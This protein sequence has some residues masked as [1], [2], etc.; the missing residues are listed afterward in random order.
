VVPSWAVI[1]ILAREF[2]VTALRTVA[3]SVGRVIAA[4]NW[5]KA[6]MVVQVVAISFLLTPL[7]NILLG[8]VSVGDAMMWIMTLITVWSGIDY[9]Y[10]NRDVFLTAK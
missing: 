6:K 3:M 2:I 5:G 4:N 10:V 7:R 9:C 8:F 1:L